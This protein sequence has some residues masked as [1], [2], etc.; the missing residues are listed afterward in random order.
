MVSINDIKLPPHHVDAEKWTIAWVLM[1]NEMMYVY[2]S[3]GLHSSDFYT[4]AHNSIYEAMSHLW[5]SRTVIDAVTLSNELGKMKVL[6]AV[7]GVDYLYELS[8]HV[9]STSHCPEYA[10]IVK[11]KATLRKVLSTSQSIIGDVYDQKDTIDILES[12]EKRIFDLTQVNISDRVRHISDILNQR[13]EQY[14][15]IVDDPEKANEGKTFSLY[16]K[17]DEALG[18]FKPG[19]LIILAA[20][21]AM[22][23]TAFSLNLLMNAAIQQQKTVALFSLEMPAEQIVDRILSTLARIPINKLSKG[24]IDDGD[25]ARIGDAMSQLEWTDIY[26]DDKGA[27]TIATLRSKLRRLKVEKWQLDLVVIDYLQLMSGAW[28]KFAGNRVMEISEISRSLKEMAKELG[29][30]IIALSQLSRKVEDTIDKM[31]QLS[32]LR[33][34]WSIEQDADSVLMLHREEYYDPDTDRKGATDILIR[35]N[36][37]GPIAEVEVFFDAPTM[38]FVDLGA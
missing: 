36:R 9:L 16:A 8:T 23:K 22:G 28:S 4:R 2:E 7:G 33:D 17:L 10:Q 19:E 37:N 38:R 26:I 25:F 35:K 11:E 30:P 34:S 20:R 3:M 18:G 13:V 27:V 29:A 14:T 31:P 32:H 24:H 6:D 1:D 5:G 21:P 12:I 15:A